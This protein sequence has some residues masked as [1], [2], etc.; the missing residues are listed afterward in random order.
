MSNDLILLNSLLNQLQTQTAISIPESEFFGLFSAEQMTKEYD[1]SYDSLHDG[2]VDGGGDGAI[3]SIF[4]FINNELLSDDFD[5]SNIKKN[6]S[7]SLNLIQSKTSNTFSE[8]QISKTITNLMDLFDLSKTEKDLKQQY[9]SRLL[10][11]IFIFRN[12]FIE[13]SSKHPQLEINYF[14]VTKGSTKEIHPNVKSKGDTLI[15]NIKSFF[16]DATV[17]VKYVGAR[18]LLNI[19]RV[20]KKYTL[21]LN[22]EENYISRDNNYVI[23]SNLV[24]YFNFVTDENKNLRK[25]IFEFNVRDYE[26]NVE[27]NRDISGTLNEEKSLDFW[28]LN[29]GITIICSKASIV[30]K[31]I[32]MDDVQIVN[33][34]QTTH[35]IFKFISSL[36]VKENEKRSLLIKIIVTNDPLRMDKIIKATNFQTMIRD[37]SFKATDEIQRDIE[38]Y[39]FQ[40]GW[41]YERRKNY[42]KNLNKPS[43]KIINIAYLAQ[44]ILA[45]LLKE[46]NNSRGRPTT[47]IKQQKDYS[48]IFNKNIK[49]S[50]MLYCAKLMKEIDKF[51]RLKKLNIPWQDLS[52]IRF[53]IALQY[54]INLLGENYTLK[55]VETIENN[56]ILNDL[57]ETAALNSW[58][59]VKLYKD[60]IEDDS[61]DKIAKSKIFMSYF[62]SSLNE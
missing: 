24:D 10:N 5:L 55:N 52:N 35:T 59:K 22:F 58:E 19:S 23:L 48:R 26:G 14:Y 40:N 11:N 54:L 15:K 38:L 29:N 33:G 57:I 36:N 7:I 30:G 6:P 51:V 32:S 13:L 18:E 34:L 17:S 43:E 20:E 45:M 39:F 53:H 42:Y 9:N 27:V 16:S 21:Q 3:D 56:P 1:L 28:N 62:L 12:S 60:D 49:Y 4:T 41:F 47:L 37:S 46:P 25:Y 8:N 50:T 61:T 31:T 2:I 44:S